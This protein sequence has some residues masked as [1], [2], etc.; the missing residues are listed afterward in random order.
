MFWRNKGPHAD[1]QLIKILITTLIYCSLIKG[2]C[3]CFL[4]IVPGII[5]SRSTGRS[6]QILTFVKFVYTQ[7]ATRNLFFVIFVLQCPKRNK[8]SLKVQNCSQNV[9][10]QFMRWHIVSVRMSGYMCARM[11][12]GMCGCV[13]MCVC[14]CVIGPLSVLAVCLSLCPWVVLDL[15]TTQTVHDSENAYSLSHYLTLILLW[16]LFS[17]SWNL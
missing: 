7:T 14:M 15:E 3:F 11:C 12:V 9:L 17:S 13:C 8:S 1:R 6:A 5:Y 2:N 16:Y 10:Y 4:L